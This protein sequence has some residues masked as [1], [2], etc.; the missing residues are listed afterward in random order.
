[1]VAFLHGLHLVEDGLGEFVGARFAAHVPGANLTVI[2][3]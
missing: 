1:M 3:G 2:L